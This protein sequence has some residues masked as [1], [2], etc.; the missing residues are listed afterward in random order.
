M[1]EFVKSF[2][3]FESEVAGLGSFGGLRYPGQIDPDSDTV[4]ELRTVNFKDIGWN[5]IGDNGRNIIWLKPIFPFN[6]DLSDGIIVDIQI[7][8]DTFYQ[9]HIGLAESLQG[10]GLGSKI[11]ASLVLNFGHLYSGK[12]RRHNPVVNRIWRGLA[13]IPEFT[14]VSGKIGDLCV[15]NENPDAENLIREFKRLDSRLSDFKA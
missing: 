3:I 13:T 7:I 12:G 11:Y 14:C 15:L 6:A 5:Q 8:R 10:I 9:I 1:E 4:E 2:N